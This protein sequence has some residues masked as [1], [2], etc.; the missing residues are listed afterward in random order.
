MPV[1][2]V[3][4]KNNRVGHYAIIIIWECLYIKI[5]CIIDSH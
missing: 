2:D 4:L 5:L 1:N 3:R